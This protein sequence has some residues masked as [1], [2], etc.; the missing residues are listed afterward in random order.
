MLSSQDQWAVMCRARFLRWG[1]PSCS[2]FKSSVWHGIKQHVPTVKMN[3]RWLIGTGHS[4]LFWLDNLLQEPLV[5]MFNFPAS[6]YHLFTAPVSKFITNR[7]WKIPSSKLQHERIDQVVI[8]HQALE[9][10][11]VWCTSKDGNLSAKQA[12]AF[13]NPPQQ[14][15]F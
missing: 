8:P 3:S 11:L 1:Q 7:K 13:L 12:Y 14:S 6:S 15:V 4:V 10:R 9:D 5:D 2:F